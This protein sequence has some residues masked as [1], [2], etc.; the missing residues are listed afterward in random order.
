MTERSR[1]LFGRD[2]ELTEADV[3]LDAAAS[4]TP[5]VLLVGGDAGIGK[6]TL[7]S[8]IA[9]RAR[10]RGATVLVGHCLDIDAGAALRR[11]REALGGFVSVRAAGALPPVTRRLSPSL[12]DGGD[13]GTVEELGL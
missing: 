6:T 8:A 12:R 5:Q 10:G 4:G 1:G 11:G 7:V 9:E 2:R 13:A 3:A